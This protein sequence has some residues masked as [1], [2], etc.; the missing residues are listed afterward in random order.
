MASRLNVIP[1]SHRR[2]EV[3]ASLD[4]SESAEGDAP[5]AGPADETV[6][7]HN[8]T[9][10][11]C[12]STISAPWPAKCLAAIA[13]GAVADS[14]A[15]AAHCQALVRQCGSRTPEPVSPLPLSSE[16]RRAGSAVGI[17][18]CGSTAYRLI[19]RIATLPFHSRG[20]SELTLAMRRRT[21]PPAPHRPDARCRPAGARPAPGVGPPDWTL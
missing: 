16:D 3:V 10:H 11:L 7:A 2:P 4:L 13:G 20:L 6:R 21:H 14:S 12:A 8:E 17:P 18:E 19:D 15:L 1:M 5:P 9:I